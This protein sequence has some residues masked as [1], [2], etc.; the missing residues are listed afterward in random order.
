MLRG[1]QKLSFNV[2]GIL[3]RDPMDQLADAADPMNSRIGSL[4]I[5][6]LDFSDKLRALVP[7]VRLGTGIIVIA[8]APGFN[9]VNTGLRQGDLIHSLNRTSIESVEQLRAAASRPIPISRLRDG[10]RATCKRVRLLSVRK[11][12]RSQKL[13]ET[14]VVAQ[15]VKKRL[16]GY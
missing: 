13:R 9:S 8:Q 7:D 2:P 11:I 14:A 3:A 12:Q 5:F 15:R 6:G 4:G 16:D 1:T 10:I